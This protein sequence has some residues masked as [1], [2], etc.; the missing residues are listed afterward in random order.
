MQ[1][2]PIIRLKRLKRMALLA[3]VGALVAGASVLGSAQANAATVVGTQAGA[4]SISPATGPVTT[5]GI[6]Y[7]TTTAC[8]SGF[9]GSGIVRIVDPGTGA[10]ASISGANNNVTAPFS[11][12]FNGTFSLAESVFPD[13][14]GTTSEIA[15]YCFSGASA[16]GSSE[17][18]QY[19]FVSISADGSTYTQT[20]NS[21]PAA[22]T[23]TLTA[24]PS[25]ATVGQTVTLT[26]TVAPA[27]AAGTVQFEVGGTAIGTPVTVA[28]GVASTTTT[29]SAAGT[30]ALSAVFTPTSST[31]YSGSTGTASLTVQTASSNSGIEPLAVTV[32]PVGSF[33][34]TV[35]T[36]TVNLSVSTDGSTGTGALNPVT[37]SDTRNTY[38]G[39][40][41]S[42]Q[43]GN[44]TGSGSAAGGTISGNQLG[45]TPSSTTLATGVTL[46]SPVTPASPGLGTTAAVLASV[47][48]GVGNGYGTSTFGANLTLAIPPTSPAGPYTSSLT[49]TAVTANP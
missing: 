36:G 35:G 41:V 44:W 42:G 33:T 15:V 12:T 13:I 28:S 24:S 40:S 1:G 11:G 10:T 45:W 48:A 27:A 39:W 49:I 23:T 32:P 46:G 31:A 5:T 30:E 2:I 6:A 14:V 18:V 29:F 17:P 4:L 8:P 22:T 43:D 25:P 26:A 38:P 37:V 47:V 21:G 3:G 9:N 34:L 16:T 19:T 20:T 7:T